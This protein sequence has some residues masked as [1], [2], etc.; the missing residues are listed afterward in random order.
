M[1]Y[2]EVNDNQSDDEGSDQVAEVWSILSV[3]GLLQSVKLVWLGQQEVEQGNDAAFE[4]SSLVSSN[5]DWGER[6]PE[7][8]FA[9]VSGN[10]EGD[11]GSETISLLQKFVKHEH[12]ESG[13]EELDDDKQGGDQ[14][15]FTDWAVHS[16][17]K[18]SKS[19]SESDQECEQ[20]GGSLV[21][22]SVFFALHVNINHLGS[23][24]ELEDH[25]RG[26]DWGHTKLHDG[27]LVGGKDNSEPIQRI[28]SF[29]L[30]NAVKW[31]LTADQVNEQGPGG[32]AHLVTEGL[33]LEWCLNFWEVVDDGSNQIQKSHWLVF[34]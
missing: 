19:F 14:S 31:D 27:T 24:E 7:D 18:I 2:L 4:F 22:F 21:E 6:F 10:E 26:N 34:I 3:E 11:T 9:D 16:G 33:F 15:E 17:Q 5:G 25:T 1:T 20:L 12:H 23:D 13:K 29:L 28:G 8:Q 30:D 32:P